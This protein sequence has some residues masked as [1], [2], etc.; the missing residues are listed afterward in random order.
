M[1]NDGVTPG[2]GN[3]FYHAVPQQMQRNNI[4]VTSDVFQYPL[5]THLQLICRYVQMIYHTFNIL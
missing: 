3:C 4:H 5:P 1:C 2:D